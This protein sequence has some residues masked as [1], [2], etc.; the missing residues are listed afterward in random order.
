MKDTNTVTSRGGKGSYS[1]F[2]GNQKFSSNLRKV[3][4]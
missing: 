1:A 2:I 3:H 4:N